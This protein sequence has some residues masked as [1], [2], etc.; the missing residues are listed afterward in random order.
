MFK[1]DGNKVV[2]SNSNRFNKLIKNFSKF[3]KSKNNKSKNL[4]YIKIIDKPI[5]LKSSTKKVI[6][7]LRQIFI[8]T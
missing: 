2:K 4:T 6:K 5:F 3:K 8:K 1:T 7:Y